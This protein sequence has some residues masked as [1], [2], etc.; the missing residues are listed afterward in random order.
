M[1]FFLQENTAGFEPIVNQAREK[2]YQII[3]RFGNVLE[4]GEER[5][6]ISTLFWGPVVMDRAMVW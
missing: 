1:S 4:H 5:F 3:L 2:I 6:P